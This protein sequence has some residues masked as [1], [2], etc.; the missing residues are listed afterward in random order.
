MPRTATKPVT[1][2]EFIA[3]LQKL[4][5]DA[6]VCHQM[7][8]EQCLLEL[9]RIS[10]EALCEPRPDGWV[11]NYRPDKPTIQYLVLPGN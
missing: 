2:G 10:V 11:P 7:Y 4:P 3:Y 1:V 6:L 8:S 9:D 5:Q